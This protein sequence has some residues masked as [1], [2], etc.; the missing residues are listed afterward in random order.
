MV[1]RYRQ[2]RGRAAYLNKHEPHD[3]D[4][5]HV[6][7][8]DINALADAIRACDPQLDLSANGQS[9]VLSNSGTVFARG[10]TWSPLSSETAPPVRLHHHEPVEG[11]SSVWSMN[12]K[13][14]VDFR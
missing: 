9:P 4:E 7:E 6:L 2:L 10:T 1:K 14:L 12:E 13:P 8:A 3:V 5:I 11:E